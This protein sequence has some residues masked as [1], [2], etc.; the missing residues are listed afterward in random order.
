MAKHYLGYDYIVQLNDGRTGWV[1]TSNVF[2]IDYDRV[3]RAKNVAAECNR[4]GPPKIGM[5]PDQL[6]ATC[7]GRPRRIIKLTT[8][9]GVEENYIYSLGHV[10]KFRE[11]KVS[12][13]VEAR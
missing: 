5:T 12:E 13:I 4:R 8:A 7:W 10:V 9:A 11:G 6:L 1:D 2:L 3:A